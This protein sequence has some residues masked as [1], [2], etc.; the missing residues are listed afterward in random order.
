MNTVRL[1]AENVKSMLSYTCSSICVVMLLLFADA[2]LAGSLIATWS[3]N[4]EDDLAGYII[5]Y[6]TESGNYTV[7][8]DVGNTTVYVAEDLQDG[9]EYYFVVKAY[10]FAGNVSAPSTE[11]SATVGAANLVALYQT[12]TETVKLVWTPVSGADGYHVFRS[13]IPYFT[14]HTPIATVE[15]GI[16]Q[17]VDDEHTAN[18][19]GESYYVVQAVAGGNVVYTFNTVGAFDLE[20][21]T[22]LNLVS[23]PLIPSDPSIQFVLGN[24]L[25]GGESATNA[26]QIRI[27]NGEEYEIN[28]YYDG[29]VTEYK[30][31]WIDSETGL[32]ST[33]NMDPNVGFWLEVKESHLDTLF[34]LTGRVPTDTTRSITLQPGFNFVSSCYPVNVPLDQT[35]LYED[36]VMKGGVGSGEADIIRAWSG[37]A[38]D[39]AWV[40]D[41]TNSELDGTWMDE[42]GK[43]ETTI[44]MVPGD[45]YIIWKK[46]DTAENV[47]TYPNPAYLE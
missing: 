43:N 3:A 36:G 47:W 26:D 1:T 6:G 21:N 7:E 11:V 18:N 46:N 31:K 25:T 34:T 4:T 28:W 9:Q 35:E 15:A 22:G 20:L 27:W 39:Q 2:S 16:F 45:G 30:G 19:V 8:E 5:Y 14:P 12:E 41:G 42:T 40:V 24:Q 32:I 10:D 17:Y 33:Y 13:S 38:Y 44:Q 23:L 29:P 37:K